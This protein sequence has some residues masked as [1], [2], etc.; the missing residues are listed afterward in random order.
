MMHG[1]KNIKLKVKVSLTSYEGP[2]RGWNVCSMHSV[3]CVVVWI[4]QFKLQ[5]VGY[6]RLLSLA[7]FGSEN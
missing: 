4:H 2:D 7:K 6:R 1:Q 3:M 5:T